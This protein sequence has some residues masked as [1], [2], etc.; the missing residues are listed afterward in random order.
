MFKCEIC[1]REFNTLAGL[2]NH[3]GQL[4]KPVEEYYLKFMNPI[5]GT[6]KTCG[7]DTSF[8]NLTK[9]YSVYCCPACVNKDPDIKNKI[10]EIKGPAKEKFIQLKKIK[11]TKIKSYIY[12]VCLMVSNSTEKDVEDMSTNLLIFE[13]PIKKTIE[14][15]N[16][17]SSSN[18]SCLL[19]FDDGIDDQPQKLKSTD[20]DI[21]KRNLIFKTYKLALIDPRFVSE[22][23]DH[24]WKCTTCG[25]RFTQQ[26]SNIRVGHVCK[27]CHPEQLTKSPA[28]SEIMEFIQSVSD[29]EIQ[30]NIAGVIP[31]GPLDLYI[32]EKRV[33]IEFVEIAFINAHYDDKKYQIRKCNECIAKGIRLLTIFEDEWVLKQEIVKARLKRILGIFDNVEK[34]HGRKCVI[35]EIPHPAIKNEFLNKFHIQGKDNAFLKLGAYYNGVLVSVMTFG[36]GNISKG[37]K[38]VE[39]LWELNRFASDRAYQVN[40][41]ASKLL[42]YF[43]K[44]YEWNEIFS[45]ADLRWSNGDVYSKLGFEFSHASDSNYFYLKDFKRFHRFSLRKRAE[46]P[47]DVTEFTIRTAEGYLRIFDCGNLKFVMK[48]DQDK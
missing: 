2:N 13:P 25:N 34:V 30:S 32:P 17:I 18:N 36:K 8:L 43:K 6:C 16:K 15:K 21:F 35:K 22:S 28:E 47:R 10:R 26:W 41:I 3:V 9:G 24:Q 19:A 11:S 27:I 29:C 1:N 7:K 42:S 4:H 12:P 38:N 14:I 48:K 44:N 46:E 20:G 33:A 5:K 40:G 23:Y 31:Y 39:G 37:S 45:Y